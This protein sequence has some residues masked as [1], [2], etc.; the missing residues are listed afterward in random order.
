MSSVNIQQPTVA[1]R[2][3]TGTPSVAIVDGQSGD[4]IQ[5]VVIDS[6]HVSRR[7]STT[8]VITGTGNPP[9]DTMTWNTIVGEAAGSI[10]FTCVFTVNYTI[11]G[12]SMSHQYSMSE[13]LQVV[14]EVISFFK[15]TISQAVYDQ[16]TGDTTP[17]FATIAASPGVDNIPVAFNLPYTSTYSGSTTDT[18]AMIMYIDTV[19]VVNDVT[20]QGIVFTDIFSTS[21]TDTDNSRTYRLFIVNDAL[22]NGDHSI[23][24]R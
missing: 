3:I 9:V 17:P 4:A 8:R 13:V 2:T 16:F 7:D 10:T 12:T 1:I 15:G 23:T 21:V 24:W 20:S 11:G 22:T 19:A 5:S 6:A 18:Y 14:P